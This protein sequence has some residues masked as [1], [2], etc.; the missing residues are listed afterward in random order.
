MSNQYY[1]NVYSKRLNRYGN[2]FQ[3]RLEGLRAKEFE[4]FLLKSPNRIDF[5]FDGNIVAG[6]L[7]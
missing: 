7:E 1:T 4:H 6:V 2:D 3:S 5:Q